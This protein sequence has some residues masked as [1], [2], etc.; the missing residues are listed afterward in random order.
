MVTARD[1][2]QINKMLNS[3]KAQNLV[4]WRISTQLTMWRST[5]AEL[6]LCSCVKM[7]ILKPTDV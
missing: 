1:F 5:R 6:L 2:A 7:C 4:R 3:P